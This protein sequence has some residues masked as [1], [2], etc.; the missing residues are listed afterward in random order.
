MFRQHH[1]RR[2]LCRKEIRHLLILP[3]R[4]DQNFMAGLMIQTLK[5]RSFSLWRMNTTEAAR[6]VFFCDELGDH[7]RLRHSAPVLAG[8]PA[9]DSGAHHPKPGP[10]K[11]NTR[12]GARSSWT[13]CRTPSSAACPNSQ[14]AEV[15]FKALG[16]RT[17][18][19]GSISRGR[20]SQPEPSMIERPHDPGRVKSILKGIVMNRHPPHADPPAPT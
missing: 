12:Q 16:S 9:A 6:R 5:R 20:K 19:S 8:R 15:L 11:K 18:M 14:T 4:S 1:R 10:V 7:A 13:M 17:V 3:E 2:E